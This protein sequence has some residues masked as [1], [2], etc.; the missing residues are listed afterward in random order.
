[1]GLLASSPTVADDVTEQRHYWPGDEHP[2]AITLRQGAGFQREVPC[3]TALA[4][5]VGACDGTLSVGAICAA[6]A[7]LLEVDAAELTAEVEPQL[8]ELLFTGFLLPA[9]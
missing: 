8:R 2:A 5:V 6:V 1:H 4:A 7:D 9:T 3:G